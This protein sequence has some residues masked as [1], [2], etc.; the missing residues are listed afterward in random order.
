MKQWAAELES[1]V[2]ISVLVVVILTAP[3]IA[4]T[5]EIAG[6]TDETGNPW[7]L[8]KLRGEV[9]IVNF[10]ATWCL[11]CVEELPLLAR[12]QDRYRKDGVRVVGVSVD[13]PANRDDVFAFARAH[14]GQFEVVIGGTTE[15]MHDLGL[16][17]ELPATAILDA[18]G[19]VVARFRGVVSKRELKRALDS[20]LRG[21]S[22]AA[23]SQRVETEDR[24]DEQR[25]H[26]HGGDDHPRGDKG[27]EPDPAG[28]PVTQASLV[29]S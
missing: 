9:V 10:W 26:E 18:S 2:A 24:H 23:D 17:E 27:R 21:D 12:M 8:A 14:G 13:D 19:A 22:V 5:S 16:G 11:P 20:A 3:T 1:R 28:A 6:W 25:A 7:S 15:H 4:A 29:P